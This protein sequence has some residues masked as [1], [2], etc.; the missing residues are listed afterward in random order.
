MFFEYRQQQKFLE[1]LNEVNVNESLPPGFEFGDEVVNLDQIDVEG[2]DEG[3]FEEA[4]AK[5]VDPNAEPLPTK[6]KGTPADLDDIVYSKFPEPEKIKDIAKGIHQ[7]RLAGPLTAA[8]KQKFIDAFLALGMNSNEARELLKNQIKKAKKE[9]SAK[10]LKNPNNSDFLAKGAERKQR[11]IHNSIVLGIITDDGTRVSG[12]KFKK[13]INVIP[14]RIVSNNAKIDKSGR[15]N[16]RFYE[17]TLPAYQGLY[18]DNKD[19]IFRLLRTCPSAGDCKMYCYATKGG[20]VQYEGTNLR[21]IRIL[22][23]LMNDWKGFKNQI[24][25]ELKEAQQKDPKVKLRW[26]DS[27]DF[28]VDSYVEL[29]FDVARSTPDVTHYAY[30][31]SVGMIRKLESSKPKNFVFNFSEGGLQDKKI[32]SDDKN[33]KVI[34]KALWK[35]LFKDKENFKNEAKLQELKPRLAEVYGKNGLT[36]EN[37]LTYKELMNTPES[38]EPKWHVIVTPKDGD[39]SASR[40]DVISTLLLIH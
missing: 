15:T 2:S 24:M 7:L 40:T 5:Q 34:P 11:L 9:F 23:Y 38:E 26:H 8:K 10:N 6:N 33:S 12:D 37:I 21:Q 22:N 19:D 16:E 25:R 1:A 39:D 29:A 13:L 31:K 36:T 35:D 14:D 17:I 28:F 3:S 30:T 32:S 20:Y 18:Y 4:K 27:G